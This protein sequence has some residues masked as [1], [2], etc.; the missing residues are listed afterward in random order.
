[1]HSG[2]E[3]SRNLVDSDLPK[4]IKVIFE[5]SDRFGSRVFTQGELSLNSADDS[6]QHHVI[7]RPQ[8]ANVSQYPTRA[9]IAADSVRNA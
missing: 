1:M 6:H 9:S 3:G 7:F 5:H 4:S 8:R 2:V